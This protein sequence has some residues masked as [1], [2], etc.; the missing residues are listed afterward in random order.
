[1]DGRAVVGMIECKGRVTNPKALKV[2]TN[3]PP[4]NVA[5]KVV[6]QTPNQEDMGNFST[7]P[8][9]TSCLTPMLEEA[10][11]TL[12]ARMNFNAL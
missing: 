7:F 2:L 12:V 4:V 11:D 3:R 6:L 8:D 10:P 9:A 5:I 1:M